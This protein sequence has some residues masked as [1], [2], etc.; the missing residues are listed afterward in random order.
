MD[1]AYNPYELPTI[2][3]RFGIYVISTMYEYKHIDATVPPLAQTHKQKQQ[4]K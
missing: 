4:T 3:P 1:D 2:T